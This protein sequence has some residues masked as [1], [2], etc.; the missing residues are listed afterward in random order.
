LGEALRH[1]VVNEINHLKLKMMEPFYLYP[2]PTT[3]KEWAKNYDL[4]QKNALTTNQQVTDC[5]CQPKTGT[6]VAIAKSL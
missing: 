5:K 4:Q 1:Q 2:T 6:D 3:A